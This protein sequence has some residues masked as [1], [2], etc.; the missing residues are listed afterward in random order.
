[1][2]N[3]IEMG[4]EALYYFLNYINKARDYY[5]RC[6]TVKHK[7]IY[8]DLLKSPY[9]IPDIVYPGYYRP[10]LIGQTLEEVVLSETIYPYIPNNNN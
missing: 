5:T 7:E 6:T 10:Y 8:E 3:R 9:K 1:M 4:R 2:T